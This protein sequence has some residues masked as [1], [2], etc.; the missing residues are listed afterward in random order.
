MNHLLKKQLTNLP[1]LP[2]VYEFFSADEKL[3]YVGKAKNL[4]SRVRSYF[5][6]P[7]E[8]SPAKKI[9]V[10]TIHHL[11]IT[12][13]QNETEALLLEGNLIK[14]HQPPYNVVLKDDKSWLYFAIDKRETFPTV[15]L[16]RKTGVRGIKY[17][18]PYPQAQVARNSYYL[19]KKT[20][21]L[22][23]CNNPADK[24][25]F[26][27]HLGRCLGHGGYKEKILYT[28]QIKLLEQILRGDTKNLT[29]D[30][31]KQMQLASYKKQ[32]ERAGRL[33]DQLQAI[34]QFGIK[35]NVLH[36]TNESFDVFALAKN[37]ENVAISRLPVRRGALLD[38]ER[39]LLTASEQ[40]T[41]TEILTNFLEQ[42]Y[43][44]NPERPKIAYVAQ[45]LSTTKIVDVTLKIPSR[46]A[47]YQLIKLAISVAKLHLEQSVVSWARKTKHTT[48]GL[49]ELADIL[50]MP[51]TPTRIEGYD[52]SN[53]QGNL[54]VGAMVVLINGT[55]T[56]KEYRKFKIVGFKEP[57]DFAMLAQMLTRRFNGKHEWPLPNLI[58]LDG[59][60]PQ[61]S[62]VKKELDRCGIKI[63]IV[64]LAKQE[65]ILYTPESTSPIKLNRNSPA[66]Q[67]LQELRD[68]AH[69]FGITFYRAR[70][71]KQSIKSAWDELPGIG[72]KLK[73]RLKDKF[74]SIKNLRQASVSE[75]SNIVGPK[76]AKV[77]NQFLIND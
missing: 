24:P 47:K 21:G 63:P 1:T 29:H 65:E 55:P 68:E 11:Q 6:K 17:F 74:G 54:P 46:G 23:T 45:K 8:L 52:I 59:G 70:H 72:P 37:G 57:N 12:P 42:Y 39:F 51:K 56:P 40:L 44:Q 33:R 61:L 2:G 71:R 16:V 60:L 58:M 28:E 49:Q 50:K 5:Q 67:L 26:A 66:L 76:K 43:P 38:N 30:L 15:R 62:V 9:M 36:A 35:Q 18:G 41:D 75:L 31:T 4:K 22:K 77:I 25:C 73:K 48:L 34:K 64:A 3:L 20:L 10:S 53:I 7:T 14:Q 13:T 32:F 19:L 27:A 69:R